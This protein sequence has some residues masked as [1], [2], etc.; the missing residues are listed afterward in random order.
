LDMLSERERELC[1]HLA[2]FP[3]DEPA[4]LGAITELWF[5]PQPE[6]QSERR[7]L[8]TVVKPK[9]E[10]RRLLQRFADLALLEYDPVRGTARLHKAFRSYLLLS[11]ITPTRTDVTNRIET[12]RRILGGQE[13][14]LA[15]MRELAQW[16][17][18]HQQ[19]G[20]AR[21][22]LARARQSSEAQSPE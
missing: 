5:P 21:K 11:A 18:D 15:Q 6:S 4:T 7:K 20:Y 13:A 1:Q 17:S 12:A 14:T 16:L 22:L 3:A 8:K 19:F 10:T 9:D 2:Q